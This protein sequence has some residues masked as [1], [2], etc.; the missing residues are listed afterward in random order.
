M[1]PAPGLLSIDRLAVRYGA[2]EA[3]DVDGSYVVEPKNPGGP[4]GFRSLYA[5][6]PRPREPLD[7]PAPHPAEASSAWH[8]FAVTHPERDR[9]KYFSYFLQIKD[10]RPS[11]VAV[12]MPE[13]YR[14]MTA[15][16]FHFNAK[17]YEPANSTWVISHE[18][19]QASGVSY[20]RI[21]SMRSFETYEAAQRYLALRPDQDLLLAGLDPT[22]SCVPLEALDEY[23]EVYRSESSPLAGIARDPPIKVFEYNP[24]G[25]TPAAEAE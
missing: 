8:L 18:V 2:I 17:A 9:G 22:R 14:T 19:R 16:L 12:F 15:R 6:R 10:G 13:Y 1:T 24:D 21:K 20:S 3:V 5:A 11:V 25:F 23:R 7:A 4:A